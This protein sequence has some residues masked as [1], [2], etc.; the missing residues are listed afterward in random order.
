MAR[1]RGGINP[2]GIAITGAAAGV[3]GVTDHGEL[4]GLTDDDHTQ[5]LKETD[6]NAKGDLYVATA[7]NTITRLGVGANGTVLT[8]DSGEASGVKWASPSDSWYTTDL[9][10][11]D[12]AMTNHFPTVFTVAADA[13][14][15]TKGAY[16]ELI[17]STSDDC[18]MLVV[19]LGN[20]NETGVSTGVLVDIAT[21][22]AASESVV[23]ANLNAGFAANISG[24]GGFIGG[25]YYIPLAV[26]GGTRIS[27]RCS[28]ETGGNTVNVTL[29]TY[30]GGNRTASAIDTIGAVTAS[31]RGTDV[32]AGTNE[33]EGLWTEIEDSTANAYVGL[34]VAVGGA[35][36][37]SSSSGNLLID[38]GTGAA[39]AET[40][41]GPLTNLVVG[42]T[43]AEVLLYHFPVIPVTA[44]V[45]AGTRLAARIS[46][47]NSNAQSMDVI[48]YG[49]RA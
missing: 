48:L 5:Y 34:M 24:S 4:T 17:A 33:A 32:V 26:S 30:A 35:G 16:T 37:L 36:D 11:V 7:D 28:A 49:L 15:H 8:A 45:S 10:P 40:G 31:S 25:T 2:G 43:A 18:T 12:R 19:R 9:T 14:A 1:K 27:A 22:A 3:A 44:T 13:V 46:A 20:V 21:G 38:I 29:E 41:I 47:D 42:L 23:V 6:L 39:A